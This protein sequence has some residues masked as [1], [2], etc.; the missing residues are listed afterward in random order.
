MEGQNCNILSNRWKQGTA[1]LKIA[2]LMQGLMLLFLGIVSLTFPMATM[3]LVTVVWGSFLIFHA[4]F[5]LSISFSD[6]KIKLHAILGAI[7]IGAVGIASVVTPF[8]MEVMWVIMLGCW[9]IFQSIEMIMWGKRKLKDYISAILS[10]IVGIVFICVPLIGINTIGWL[11]GLLL[12]FSG[13]LTLFFMFR[14]PER[15]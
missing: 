3:W 5:L 12:A 9:Q 14:V 8:V 13:I 6:K 15:V 1:P 10:F 2:L 7:G 4:A 11:I